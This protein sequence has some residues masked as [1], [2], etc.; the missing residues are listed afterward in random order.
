MKIKM[1]HNLLLFISLIFFTSCN[2]VYPEKSILAEYQEIDI[3]TKEN[4][5]NNEESNQTDCE[6]YWK[7]RFPNDS[8]KANYIIDIIS[9]NELTENNLKFLK[10]LK[11]K[12]QD[13]MAFKDVLSPIF[14]LSNTEIGI[15]TFP[16]YSYINDKLIPA[17]I[18][19]E[20]IKKF[21]SV[22]GNKMEH[23]GE[24]KYYPML[25]NSVFNKNAKPTINLYT[26][27]QIGSTKI[28]E[29]GSYIDECLEY[30]IYSVDTT[31]ISVNDQLLFSSPFLID[32]IFEKYP[33][34]DLLLQNEYKEECFDCPSSA[35]FQ[36][37]FAKLKGTNNIYFVYADTFPINDK[38]DTPSRA[39]ILINEKEEIIYLW[40]EEMDLF[41]CRC[42]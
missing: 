18:E 16:Q 2:K 37:S 9:N 42:L 23:F 31:N 4:L 30:F 25:L 39:L 38:L 5:Q 22:T 8:L 40:Y 13:L 6:K 7:N 24:I 34:V 17:S 27:N 3:A 14:R 36:K 12:K 28:L 35:T 21:D 41:G 15:L 29:L 1:K 19:T 32:L 20:L 26:T 11:K 33:K 10:A